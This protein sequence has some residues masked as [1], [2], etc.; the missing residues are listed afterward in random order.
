M[1]AKGIVTFVLF[2]L[3][4]HM[5]SCELKHFSGQ[6][7]I[8][9][10]PSEGRSLEHRFFSDYL[11]S[12]NFLK[13]YIDSKEYYTDLSEKQGISGVRVEEN[14]KHGLLTTFKYHEDLDCELYQFPLLQSLEMTQYVGVVRLPGIPSRSVLVI[15]DDDKA[16]NKVLNEFEV[17]SKYDDYKIEFMPVK[18]DE[19]YA[20]LV[21]YS[22]GGTET[23]TRKLTIHELRHEGV[24]TIFETPSLLREWDVETGQETVTAVTL[25]Y[26]DLDGDGMREIIKNTRV[27]VH[28]GVDSGADQRVGLIDECFVYIGD[29]SMG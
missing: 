9:K 17:S 13:R 8:D 3:P 29:I 6:S 15:F 19:Q 22:H 5:C 11:V 1:G 23:Y 10:A 27:D 18:T 2:L 25:D 14:V 24:V 21:S 7:S 12:T 16:G 20:I 26:R 28:E 4:L